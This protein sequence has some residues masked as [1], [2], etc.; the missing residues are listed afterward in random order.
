MSLILSSSM[1]ALS[2]LEEASGDAFDDRGGAIGAPDLSEGATTTTATTAPT[3]GTEATTTTTAPPAPP[4][5]TV[6][7]AT[8]TSHSNGNRWTATVVI[9]ITE[10]GAAVHKAQITATWQRVPGGTTTA[11][12]CSTLPNGTCTFSLRDLPTFGNSN[13]VSQVSFTV[14]SVTPDGGTTTNPT[15]SVSVAEP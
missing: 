5:S 11:V 10:A 13:H 12:T 7:S 6:A 14:T 4:S 3:S 2:T 8:A 1:G 9:S 15:L